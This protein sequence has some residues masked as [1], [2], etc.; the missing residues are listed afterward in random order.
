LAQAVQAGIQTL[1]AVELGMRDEAASIIEDGMQQG[2]HLA[3]ARTLDVRTIE[4]V[5]LP[6]QIAVFGFE[7]L[8]RRWSE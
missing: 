2:L 8:M 5:R 3:A 1:A 7:L 6:D 4:H